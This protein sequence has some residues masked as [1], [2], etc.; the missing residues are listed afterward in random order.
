[1]SLGE[2]FYNLQERFGLLDKQNE[3]T[4]TLPHFSHNYHEPYSSMSIPF[5]Q[6]CIVFPSFAGSVSTSNSNIC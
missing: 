1:M 4:S 5:K 3:L 6:K 2:V